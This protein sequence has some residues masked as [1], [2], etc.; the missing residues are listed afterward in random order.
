VAEF[1]DIY[2]EPA[3]LEGMRP[4]TFDIGEIN[5]TLAGLTRLDGDDPADDG[6]GQQRDFPGPLDD[7][8]RDVRTV[9]GKKELRQLISDARLEEP[10]LVD[11][12]T[13]TRM[14]R[15]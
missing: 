8:I 6:A 7:L 14:V 5:E 9:A 2:G 15:P 11:A 4:T 10:V 13:A 3:D 12:A 1:S